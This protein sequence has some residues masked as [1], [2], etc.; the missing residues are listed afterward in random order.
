MN[1]PAPKSL[2]S[3]I[4]LALLCFGHN[5]AGAA[6]LVGL[7]DFNASGGDYTVVSTNAPGGAVG[8][9]CRPRILVLL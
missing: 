8:V 5:P 1:T 7:I 2:L 9:G 3:A 6:P 4:V